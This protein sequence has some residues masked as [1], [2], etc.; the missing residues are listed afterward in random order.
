MRDPPL[1]DAEKEHIERRLAGYYANPDRVTP[2]EEAL[3][4]IEAEL[5]D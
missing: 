1:S 4:E 2:F 3:D 5:G